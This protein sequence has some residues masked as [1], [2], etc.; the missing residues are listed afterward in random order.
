MFDVIVLG[1]RAVGATAAT[2]LAK[3]KRSVALVRCEPGAQAQRRIQWLNRRA[4]RILKKA[5]VSWTGL[6]KQPVKTVHFYDGALDRNIVSKFRSAPAYVVE[7]ASLEA[8]L[9]AGAVRAGA[10]YHA[11]IAA[12]SLHVAEDCAQVQLK[13]GEA[14]DGQI[15]IVAGSPNEESMRQLGLTQPA[16][17]AG[18]WAA[19]VQGDS[20]AGRGSRSVIIVLGLN[21]RWHGS[22]GHASRTGVR[23]FGYAM[24]SSNRIAIGIAWPGGSKQVPDQ[25]DRLIA[26]LAE[27]GLVPEQL[28]GAA[29]SAVMEHIPAGAALEMEAHVAKRCLLIG[30]A[31]GFATAI[32]GETLYPGMWSAQVAAQVVDEALASDNPQDQLGQFEALWRTTMGEYLRM[33]NTDIQFLLP[34]VFANQQMADKMA[35]AFF[36]GQNI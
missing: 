12:E 4:D 27:K 10:A 16:P 2:L 11:E 33:P 22:G 6:P 32:S 13:N 8:K 3:R 17:S 9:V 21:G 34:L 31:G 28:R 7:T 29:G 23:G 5:G 15:L 36:A 18:V 24:R 14:M 20:S 25:L 26:A 19:Q 30:C 1:D 35:A